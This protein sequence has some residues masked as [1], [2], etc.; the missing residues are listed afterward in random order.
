MTIQSDAAGCAVGAHQAAAGRKIQRCAPELMPVRRIDIEIDQARG[1]NQLFE[2]NAR[3]LCVLRR[4][5]HGEQGAG[6]KPVADDR[7][8]ALDRPQRLADLSA[9]PLEQ[10]AD[11][12]RRFVRA[13][14]RHRRKDHTPRGR[15]E[16]DLQQLIARF[17][18]C[19]QISPQSGE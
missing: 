13:R 19:E 9:H 6:A 10:L 18:R 14:D 3:P 17:T 4:V 15:V 1:R 5:S 8:L 2:S 11:P 12:Q 7:D 16:L